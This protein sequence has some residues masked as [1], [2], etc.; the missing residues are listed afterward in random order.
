VLAGD[1]AFDGLDVR[2]ELAPPSGRRLRLV[3]ELSLRFLVR[4]RLSA[5]LE[6]GLGF[7]GCFSPGLAVGG[8]LL[9]PGVASLQ[10]LQFGGHLQ[11]E[12][13]GAGHDGLVVPGLG[14]GGLG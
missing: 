9:V 6:F 12:G 10:P 2:L 13:A 3:R 7:P 8:P 11:G 14:V 5:P 1:G 4:L